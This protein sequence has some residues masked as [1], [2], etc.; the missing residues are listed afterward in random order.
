MRLSPVSLPKVAAAWLVVLSAPVVAEDV[1]LNVIRASYRQSVSSVTSAWGTYESEVRVT[2]ATLAAQVGDFRRERVRWAV[3]GNKRLFDQEFI[4]GN[5]RPGSGMYHMYD[6]DTLWRKQ[7]GKTREP[8]YKES[9]KEHY[10]LAFRRHT[11]PEHYMGRF[12]HYQGH[13]VEEESVESLLT[14]SDARLGGNELVDGHRCWLVDFGSI[15][16]PDK[17]PVHLRIWFDPASGFLPRQFEYRSDPDSRRDAERHVFRTTMFENLQIDGADVPFPVEMVSDGPR[18]SRSLKVTELHVNEPAPA[19]WFDVRSLGDQEITIDLND[20]RQ[21]AAFVKEQRPPRGPGA[22]ERSTGEIVG[23]AVS[24]T[25]VV[26]EADQPQPAR[27]I[28]LASGVMLCIAS[29]VIWR[30]Q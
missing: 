7:H 23:S 21:V 25:H 20:R 19:A 5:K 12:S 8:L 17:G 26:A 3:Q 11:T 18:W 27:W 6:G 14:K 22:Q 1:T 28:A 10:D 24:A 29:A 4:A 15:D 9:T 30:R 2:D 16:D 13:M